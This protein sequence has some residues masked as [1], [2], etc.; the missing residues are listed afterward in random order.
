MT[1]D[2]IVVTA[3]GILGTVIFCFAFILMV[4]WRNR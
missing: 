3:N 1:P 4:T 2:Q